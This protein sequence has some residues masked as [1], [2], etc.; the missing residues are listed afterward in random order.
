ML[1]WLMTK[2]IATDKGKY[3]MRLEDIFSNIDEFLD[4]WKASAKLCKSNRSDSSLGASALSSCKS[5]GYRARDSKVNARYGGSKKRR[6]IKGKVRGAKY[7]GPL[8][9]YS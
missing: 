4:E 3:I 2:P 6:P 7:G 5:Q 8:P 9:D 1:T